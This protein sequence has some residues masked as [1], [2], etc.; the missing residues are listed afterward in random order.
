MVVPAGDLGAT[1][2]TPSVCQEAT[3]TGRPH[4]LG[5]ADR[6]GHIAAGEPSVPRPS[7]Q[8][9]NRMARAAVHNG[10]TRQPGEQTGPPVRPSQR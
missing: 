9:L 6:D 5:A 7:A 4:P 10:E 8:A 1:A 2:D 3:R